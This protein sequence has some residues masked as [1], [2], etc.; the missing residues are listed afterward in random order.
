MQ[1]IE[2]AGMYGRTG[3]LPLAS[4]TIEG[5]CASPQP[6]EICNRKCNN[7]AISSRLFSQKAQ[8]QVRSKEKTNLQ[9]CHVTLYFRVLGG[10]KPSSNTT[11]YFIRQ[12]RETLV[13]RPKRITWPQ[14]PL[15]I[16]GMSDAPNVFW[17]KSCMV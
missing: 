14:N 6:T 9:L 7:S 3:W 11:F 2:L 1:N 8:Q 16:S 17:C 10:A 4:D 15:R 13:I 12:M 5:K